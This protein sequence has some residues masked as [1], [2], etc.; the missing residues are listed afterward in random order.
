MKKRG[1]HK[2]L[3]WSCLTLLM[4][5]V[6]AITVWARQEA[7]RHVCREINV[8]VDA[9]PPLDSIVRKG[10][11]EELGSYPGKI[12][13][14]PIDQIDTRSINRYL[15]AL[16]T[17]ETVNSMVSASGELRIDVV[18][19][20]PVMRVFFGD[21]SYYINKDGKHI[22]SNAEFYND[23]PLVT[24][25]FTHSFQPHM[26]LPLVRFIVSD[27]DMREL[28]AMIE[29]HDSR[30]LL[31][32]PKIAGHVVNFGDTTRLAEKRD[33][34]KLFYS[35]V[36]PY[37]GWEEYDTI[38]VKFRG[39]VVATRRD[40]TR[41]NVNSEP[42]EEEDLEEATLPDVT[43]AAV[44]NAANTSTSEQQTNQPSGA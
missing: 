3:K 43:P 18:P 41:L 7:S 39:Q 32:I 25:H 16:N 19:M 29:A 35:K 15:G 10:V 13:G 6:V 21:N 5:Y 40:K 37:K 34:L 44:N 1:F 12:K 14:V 38:S 22:A 8:Y 17:F 33:A 26:V 42:I 28:T 23:V 31:V 30:N 4:G 9:A 36:M 27:P 11:L 20:I 2:L 24:G